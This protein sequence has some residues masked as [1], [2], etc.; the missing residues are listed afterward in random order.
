[1]SSPPVAAAPAESASVENAPFAW[2]LGVL[3]LL[4]T[5]TA[6]GLGRFSFTPLMPMLVAE[7]TGTSV[8]VTQG[9]AWMMAGY[10]VGALVAAPLGRRWGG[11]PLV[12]LSLL[13]ILLA[14][15]LES[16]P[17]SLA[18][19]IVLR[20]LCG[21]FGAVIMVLGPS[22]VLRS[23]SASGRARVAGLTYTGIGAGTLVS[24]ALVPLTGTVSSASLALAGLAG[25]AVI[26]SLWFPVGPPQAVASG[27]VS[28]GKR[29]A[30]VVAVTIAYAISGFAYIPHTALWGNFVAQELGRGVVLAGHHWML[31]GIGAISGPLILSRVAQ[32]WGVRPTLVAVMA[33]KSLMVSLP[34][35][36]QS[37]LALSVS[38]TMVGAFSPGIVALVSARLAE[39]GIE[40]LAARW[41]LATTIFAIVQAAGGW[42][43]AALY[44]HFHSYLPLFPIAG[45]SLLVAAALVAFIQ[46]E[47]S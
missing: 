3:G 1:M 6:I 31:F 33:T 43:H 24:G 23:A 37:P 12:R 13:V 26:A 42:A 35:L 28:G 10:T 18:M 11:R 14:L 45:A 34:W 15:A 46:G 38:I 9:A 22:L 17:L 32:R 25:L 2:L 8:A 29:S 27:A 40:R 47:Q 39:L 20:A 41:G 21:V 36:S 19:H 4:A 30:S 7:G 5:F 44:A 16:L